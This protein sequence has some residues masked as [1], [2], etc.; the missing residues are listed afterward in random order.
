MNTLTIE[1][2]ELCAK[3]TEETLRAADDAFL[4][5]PV[6]YLRDNLPEFLYVAS[7]DFDALRIDSAVLEVDDIFGT[8]MVLFGLEG[9][10]KEQ[11]IIR[12]FIEDKLQQQLTAFSLSFS[13]NEGLWEVNMPLDPLEGFDETMAIADVLALVYEVLNELQQTRAAQ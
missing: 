4:Q 5:Q 9:K 8:Y 6:S 2:A 10:K 11:A 12:P 7:P 1:T 3:E 13:D